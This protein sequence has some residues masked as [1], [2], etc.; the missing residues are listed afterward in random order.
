MR[1]NR[2]PEELTEGDLVTTDYLRDDKSVV[3]HITRIEP[4][5]SFGSGY[6]ASADDGGECPRCG[7]PYSRSISDVD[8][9]WFVVS[10]PLG[11]EEC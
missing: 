7:R 1:L 8:A 11:A 5:A 4:D 3:R 2:H 10:S 9:A 6:A